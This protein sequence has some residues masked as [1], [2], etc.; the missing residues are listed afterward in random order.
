MIGL[1][2]VIKAQ[3]ALKHAN[4]ILIY[5]RDRTV[6]QEFENDKALS[7]AIGDRYKCYLEVTI[8]DAGLMHIQREVKA[9]W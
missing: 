7:T 1:K 3:R 5:N 4:R 6:Y 8:D 9:D 2:T